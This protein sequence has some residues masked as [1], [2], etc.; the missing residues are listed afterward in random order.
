MGTR[1][2]VGAMAYLAGLL[3][4]LTVILIG[5]EPAVS[6]PDRWSTLLAMS[7]FKSDPPPQAPKPKVAVPKPPDPV[8]NAAQP[9]LPVAGIPSPTP[10]LAPSAAPGPA[11]SGTTGPAPGPNTGVVAPSDVS[12]AI[13]S[14]TVGQ[15]GPMPAPIPGAATSAAPVAIPGAPVAVG[16]VAAI[17]SPGWMDCYTYDAK[18]RRDPFQSMVKLLKLS[19]TRGELPPLQRLELTDVKLIGIVSDASGYYGLIQTPDGKGYTVRVGTPMGLN[20]G[21]IRLISEQRVVVAEPTIDTHGKMTSRDIEI[22]QRPKEGT[23]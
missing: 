7:L 20:N 15:P 13:V 11:P 21:T 14:P 8:V 16:S 3:A 2:D 1:R 6:A 19:Q 10:S 9:G 22:L 17:D 23:E 4:L 18:S 12:K 5:I